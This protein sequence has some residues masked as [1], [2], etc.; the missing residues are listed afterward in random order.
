MKQTPEMDGIQAE[1]RPGRITR[2]GLLG[3]D[4]RKLA[5]IIEADDA[6][7]KRLGLTHAAIAGRMR[8][9]RQAGKERLGNTTSVCPNFEVRIFS[10]RGKLPCPFHDGICRK[11]NTWVRNTRLE[12]ELTYSDLGIHMIE[13]HGFYE[14]RG[15]TY[16]AD[17]RELAEVLE[18]EGE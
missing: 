10:V 7:V 15:A 5:D 13:A 18:I 16:R 1:M 6:D 14:G 12:R 9:L 8:A 11:T 3:A 2:S 4:T 17:P